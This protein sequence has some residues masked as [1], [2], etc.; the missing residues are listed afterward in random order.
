MHVDTTGARKRNTLILSIL[1]ALGVIAALAA[2]EFAFRQWTGSRPNESGSQIASG[3]YAPAPSYAPSLAPS[4]AHSDPAS[5]PAKSY[6]PSLD[7]FGCKPGDA[8]CSGQ[9]PGS[10]HSNPPQHSAAA[11]EQPPAAQAPNDPPVVAQSRPQEDPRE[12]E[13]RLRAMEDSRAQLVALEREELDHLTGRAHSVIDRV[14]AAQ[15]HQPPQGQQLR[16]DLAFGQ[17]RLQTDLNLADAAL[18]TADV[19][20]AQKYMDMAKSELERL[21]KLLAHQ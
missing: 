16:D 14:A 9:R 12:A 4:T 6:Y 21:G 18:K 8:R 1:V 13:E 11:H 20:S 7:R 5:P 2:G 17:H 15:R 3:S 19:E 10:T